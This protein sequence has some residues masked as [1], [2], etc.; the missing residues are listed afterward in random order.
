MIVEG[1]KIFFHKQTRTGG[2]LSG[3]LAEQLLGLYPDHT[4]LKNLC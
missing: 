3:A 2:A 4:P 1:G